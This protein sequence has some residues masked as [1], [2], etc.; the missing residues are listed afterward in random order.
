[1]KKILIAVLS[2]FMLLSLAACNGNE[3]SSGETQPSSISD[4]STPAPTGETEPVENTSDTNTTEEN[5]NARPELS[6]H[7]ENLEDYDMIFL[8]YPNWNADLP[9]PLYTFLE[10]YDFNG[11]TIIPF[12]P[13]GGS[14][15]SNTIK[16]IA[17]LQP[18]ATVITD[19]FSVSREGA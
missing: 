17:N 3:N 9:M 13:H 1:M 14:G 12:C 5:Q 19:G 15:F 11:K 8:G 4:T 18:Y 16:T 10:E 2:V 6:T 7:I